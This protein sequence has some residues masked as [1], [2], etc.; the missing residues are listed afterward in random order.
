MVILADVVKGAAE[1]TIG[2]R[3]KRKHRAWIS[4]TTESLVQERKKAKA[5]IDQFASRRKLEKYCILDKQV[6][7]SARKDKQKWMGSIRAC[8]ETAAPRGG[9]R[10]L[11]QLVKQLFGKYPSGLPPGKGEDGTSLYDREKVT[12][13]WAGY[14]QELLN[15]H[16]ERKLHRIVLIGI[17]VSFQEIYIPEERWR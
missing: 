12:T 8:M 15:P 6:K 14:F 9:H 2:R 5:V 13:R 11:Y 7:E 10:Q 4:N 3:K 17:S 16:S 1:D